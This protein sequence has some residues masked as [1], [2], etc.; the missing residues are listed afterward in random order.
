MSITKEAYL[1]EIG[2][3]TLAQA[4][5]ELGLNEFSLLNEPGDFAREVKEVATDRD[6]FQGYINHY[7]EILKDLGWFDM[8]DIQRAE[9]REKQMEMVGAK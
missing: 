1:K 2:E 8:N 9:F 4:C 6:R 5:S 7:E 3:K